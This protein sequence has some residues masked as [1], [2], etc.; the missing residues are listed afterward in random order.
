M[1]K[2]RR[3]A[4][5]YVFSVAV[6]ILVLSV[7]YDAG[8][9][10]FEP[11]TYPPEGVEWSLIHSMQVVVETFTATGYGSDSP[12]YSTEMNFLVMVL[13]LTGVALFFLALPALLIPLFQEALSPSPPVSVD[14][15]LSDHVVIC[16]YTPRVAVL[17]DELG[18]SGVPYVLVEP[19][20]ERALELQ[21]EGHTV[22]HAEPESSSDLERTNLA[23]ARALVADVSD[24]VDASIVLAARQ[25]TEEC[26]VISVVKEPE[27]ARYHRLAG[28]DKVVMP[29]QLLGRSLAGKLTA[30]VDVNSG[31]GIEI[32]EDLDIIEVP[33]HH[34]SAL[35]GQTLAESNIRE[36]FGVN[37]IGAWFHGKFETPPPPDRALDGGTVLLITGN[38][39][40]L[41]ALKEQVHS[42]VR[43]HR[44]GE[45]IIVGHGEVGRTVTD[46]L[47]T[48]DVP[49]TVIDTQPDERVDVVGDA[50]DPD[51]MRDA[52]VPEARSVV[53]N[54][55]DDTATEFATLVARDL[56]ETAE[57]VARSNST[58]AVRKTYRAGA[59][60]VLSLAA[61]SGRAIASTLLEGKDVLSPGQTVGVIRTTAPGLADKTL[62]GARVRERTDCTVVAVERD[63][64]LVTDLDPQF[65]FE[66][67]DAL[68]IAG[69]DSG[70]NQFVEQ[71]T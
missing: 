45:T 8:M 52:G 67:G 46:A 18:S 57:I 43:S 50:T 5:Y 9:K 47:E 11:T 51:V 69:P 26:E 62:A 40:Q 1:G 37:V 42:T 44:R 29:R 7:V 23:S 19:N 21:Q 39:S 32:D 55:P 66:A 27:H 28:A 59:D 15:D 61:V 71:F 63:G 33:V 53:L 14:A 70:I 17:I 38:E 4:A 13:D 16:T 65:R 6:L 3:R 34:G 24:R 30:G 20:A 56:T 58:E 35:A 22:V 54:L 48:A 31:G 10:A 41:R 36:R 64:S 49:Y 2:L 60:Y 25:V 12:W 68:V